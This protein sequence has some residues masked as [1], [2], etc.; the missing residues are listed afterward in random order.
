M[1]VWLDCDP[2]N[3]DAFAILLGAKHPQ[4]HLL[5]ISTVHGNASLAH[6]TA[7]AL[8][9]LE[10]L[11][12]AQDEIK[13]YAGASAPLKVKPQYALDVHGATG[14]GNL[15][16]PPP[17]L[18]ASSDKPYLDAMRD[19]IMSDPGQVCLVC[20][21]AM[22]NYAQLVEK[23]PETRDALKCV[24]MMG[25]AINC[26]N[27]APL[28]EFNM[29]CDPHAAAVVLHDTKLAEKTILCPL[30]VTHTARATPQV[31]LKIYSENGANCSYIRKCFHHLANFAYGLY[32]SRYGDLDGVPVHDP[33]AMFAA[34]AFSKYLDGETN[35]EFSERCDLHFMKKRVHV[36]VD[37]DK[38]GVTELVSGN[39]DLLSKEDGGAC[40]VQGINI[41]FF[42]SFVYEA[43]DQ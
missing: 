8:S 2:G 20:T 24:A 5:G 25:G 11:G 38:R 12:F 17:S 10:L 28:A 27:I 6:T 21:G 9:L 4:F 23:Y 36:Y 35:D 7:N 33:L 26:G 39:Q 42:W 29:F 40:F 3:D 30:N 19:A 15:D 1:K 16:L 14:M 37:G 13:V 22:T 34:L 31:L 18:K 41:P 43:L 32:C